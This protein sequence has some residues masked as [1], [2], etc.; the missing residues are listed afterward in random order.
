MERTAIPLD[1]S[2]A[3]DAL[4]QLSP[5]T[6]QKRV[7]IVVVA[8]VRESMAAI[9]QANASGTGFRD[10]HREPVSVG[11]LKLRTQH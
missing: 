9:R 10:M 6:F 8:E 4:Q 1:S 7:N 3:D 5:R 2:L 11:K